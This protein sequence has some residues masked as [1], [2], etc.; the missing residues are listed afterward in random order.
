MTENTDNIPAPYFSVG[1][2][3]ILESVYLPEHN[4]EYIVQDRQYKD[5][6]CVATGRVIKGYCYN[7]GFTAKTGDSWWKESC[8]TQEIPTI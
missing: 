8:T 3:V 7:L 6:L 1:E 4:G 5:W 2:E